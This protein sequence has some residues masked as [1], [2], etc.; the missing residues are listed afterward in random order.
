[1]KRFGKIAVCLAGGLALNAG[2]RA[3]DASQNPLPNNPYALIVARNVFGLN[4][5]PPP[6]DPNAA[7]E[8]NLPK[9]TPLGIYAVYDH[10]KVLFKVAEAGK[11]GKKSEDQY[12]N[13][14]EGEAQDE[15]EV[16]HID[17]ANSMVTF[18]NHGTQQE[19]PLAAPSPSSSPSPGPGPGGAPSPGRPGGALPG[20][21]GSSSSPGVIT[22]GSRDGRGGGGGNPNMA[23]N[24]M[25]GA[26]GGMAGGANGG[27]PLNFGSSSQARTFQ[28]TEVLPN[29]TPEQQII[30]METKRAQLMNMPNP[31][32]PPGLIPPTPITG[33]VT[34]GNNDN[35]AQGQ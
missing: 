21:G 28:P 30:V 12:Y 6:P 27:V 5:P 35:A 26:N 7:K 9:I 34:G 29:M 11:P 15:I 25:S 3:D 17:N 19:L 22:F 23:N 32:Y 1:M 14:S 2:L 4:P 10:A 33:E 8:A 31:P 20:V 16:V 13:L 18:N 24:S